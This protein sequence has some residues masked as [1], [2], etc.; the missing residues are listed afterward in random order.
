MSGSGRWRG[1]LSPQGRKLL[2]NGIIQN[3]SCWP[4]QICSGR[5]NAR[6]KDALID[7]AKSRLAL[8]H[9]S[10]LRHGLAG[11]IGHAVIS[12]LCRLRTRTRHRRTDRW[13]ERQHQREQETNYGAV[14][15]HLRPCFDQL[16]NRSVPR[17]VE[18]NFS[19]CAEGPPFD[20]L[21][22]ES[23][24]VRHCDQVGVG[25]R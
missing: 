20:R 16:H 3:V 10:A 24:L 23:R 5:Q 18:L 11:A 6:G 15:I 13:C 2:A 17:C 22:L 21:P 1:G 8:R 19:C 7:A 25:V 9:G 12:H 4:A 14:R